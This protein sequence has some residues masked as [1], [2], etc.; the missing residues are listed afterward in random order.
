MSLDVLL[1]FHFLRIPFHFGE[2]GSGRIWHLGLR[3]K[4]DTRGCASS[5]CPWILLGHDW[6]DKRWFSIFKRA[7]SFQPWIGIL[8]HNTRCKLKCQARFDARPYRGWRSWTPVYNS[9]S[10][11]WN[12]EYCFHT[13][14]ISLNLCFAWQF[15]KATTVRYRFL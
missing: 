2:K 7:V 8:R 15:R 12:T 9:V 10:L 4:G 13:I 6:L 14:L 3:V 1:W 11:K 5:E